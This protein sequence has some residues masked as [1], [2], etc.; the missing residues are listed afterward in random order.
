MKKK[1]K[2]KEEGSRKTLSTR[3]MKKNGR[4][5]KE[6]GKE[7]QQSFEFMEIRK[8]ARWEIAA[9]RPFFRFSC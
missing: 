9:G 4:E 3:E 2:E 6:K 7:Q 8:R 5:G 1:E